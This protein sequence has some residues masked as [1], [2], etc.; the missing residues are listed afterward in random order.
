MTTRRLLTKTQLKAERLRPAPA[1][2]PATAY[3]Q[4]RG[5]VALY[6]ASQAVAMRPYRSPSTAQRAALAAG[7]QLL[8]TTPCAGCGQRV[9]RFM[10]DDHGACP[11]C[12]AQLAR[13]ERLRD[14]Q[15][16]RRRAAELLALDPL[17]VDAESTGLDEDAEII[18][19]AVLDRHG[20]V[21]LDTLVKPVGAVPAETTAIHGLS[22]LHLV[23]AP[24]WPAV[25]ER[26][27][28]V[29]RERL[30]VAHNADFDARLIAQSS[31]LHRVEAPDCG[32]WECTLDLLTAV[33]DGRWPSL[34]RA[35]ALAGAQPPGSDVGR[36][37][38]AIY[39]AECCRRIV[40]ALAGERLVVHASSTK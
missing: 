37:H 12:A 29:I 16:A 40:V 24:A 10:L 2:A 27:A 20:V 4:G 14:W 30:L 26:L 17:F 21:L 28:E 38:Q 31:R 39:D 15:G 18:E 32:Q 6:D 8:G 19:F 5:W 13:E 34:A 33:N 7:R 9:D 1:Q 35:M 36:P 23:D 3:W 22:D 11:G 25:A